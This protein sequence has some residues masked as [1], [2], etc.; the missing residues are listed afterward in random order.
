MN[1][2]VVSVTSSA[3]ACWLL[4]IDP[5]AAG[6]GVVI[7]CDARHRSD[8]FALEAARVLAGAGIPVRLPPPRPPTPPPRFSDRALAAPGGIEITAS[9][10][11]PAGTGHKR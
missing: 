3:L 2:A 4:Y 7:G 1:R 5:A 11:P 6:F 9:H 10:N 8:E